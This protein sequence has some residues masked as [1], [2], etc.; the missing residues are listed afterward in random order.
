MKKLLLIISLFFLG[1]AGY[2]QCTAAFTFDT[3]QEPDVFFVADSIDANWTYTW[4]FG[5]GNFGSNP[6]EIHTYDSSATYYVCLSVFDG[7][8]CYDMFCDSVT[9]ILPAPTCNASFTANVN[10]GTAIFVANP[11]FMP[12]WSYTWDFGDGNFGTGSFTQHVYTSSEEYLVCLTVFDSLTQ[13]TYTYCE[14]VDVDISCVASFTANT[15]SLTATFIGQPIGFG[16]SY[17]WSFGDFQFATTQFPFT[18]HTYN[19][20]GTYNV[21]M[22]VTTAS[23]SNCT[24]CDQVVITLPPPS[25]VHENKNSFEISVFP[26]PAKNS[27]SIKLSGLMTDEA[28]LNVRDITG[29]IVKTESFKNIDKQYVHSINISEMQSGIYFMNIESG[30]KT[31]TIKFIKE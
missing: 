5:D 24:F 10:A 14:L 6:T 13:C 7:V 1:Y 22:N 18:T 8:A 20:P 4:D 15:D 16:N 12:G 23:G 11:P 26:N 3:S 9:V 28:V 17:V 31:K 25:S 21:C 30:Q 19:A 2:S 29:R 27:I